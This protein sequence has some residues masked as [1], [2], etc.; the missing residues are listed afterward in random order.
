MIVSLMD[1]RLEVDT[2]IN[3]AHILDSIC[4]ALLSHITLSMRGFV[5]RNFPS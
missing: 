2:S 1:I 4:L 5:S 3:N